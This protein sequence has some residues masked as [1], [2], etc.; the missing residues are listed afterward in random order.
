MAYQYKRTPKL[1]KR[2][3]GLSRINRASRRTSSRESY[4]R[5]RR[6]RVKF[7]VFSFLIVLF[8]GLVAYFLF[9]TSFFEIRDVEITFDDQPYLISETEMKSIVYTLMNKKCL[10]FL[11]CSNFFLFNLNRLIDIA[12]QDSRIASL[13]VS[14]R[15]FPAKIE[16]KIKE[17]QPKVQLVVLGSGRNYYLNSRGQMI[18]L[19]QDSITGLEGQYDKLFTTPDNNINTNNVGKQ[20]K[21][22]LPIFLDKTPTNLND[23]SIIKLFKDILDF[24][25][26]DILAQ[27]NTSIKLV[28][29]SEGGGIFDVKMTTLEGWYILINSEADF[30]KQLNSLGLILKEKLTNREEIKYINLQFGEKIFYKLIGE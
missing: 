4:N 9:L 30:N 24:I 26:S 21:M 27:N 15:L 17:S 18:I 29:I 16:V 3:L 11:S 28:E 14:K 22:P 13:I 12:R 6:T 1:D 8:L 5:R 19:Q 2:K 10:Y 23:P 7:F 25:G 20:E